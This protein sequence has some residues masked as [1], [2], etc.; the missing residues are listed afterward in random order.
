MQLQAQD[1]QPIPYLIQ[2]ITVGNTDIRKQ[3]AALQHNTPEAHHQA[4]KNNLHPNDYQPI[5]KE[6]SLS[7]RVGK[8]SYAHKDA[9]NSALP[10]YLIR[11]AL[12]ASIALAAL[13][14]V[15]VPVRLGLSSLATASREAGKFT[16]FEGLDKAIH[17]VSSDKN[18]QA[19]AG[20]GLSFSTF[21]TLF[22]TGKRNY[23]RIFGDKSAHDNA[24]AFH[25]LPR[26][27][28]NDLK[29]IA[30]VEFPA[31]CIAAIPLVTARNAFGGAA[32]PST[33]RDIIGCVPA[34]TVFFEAT[35]RLYS[36]FAN[37]QSALHG[38]Y[39]E[40]QPT[41]KSAD[42][43]DRKPY[44]EFTE[45]TPVRLAFRKLPA[46]ALGIAPYIALNRRAYLNQAKELVGE[47][48]A[49]VP[50]GGMQTADNEALGLKRDTFRSAYN[51]EIKPFL[52]FPAYTVISEAWMSNYDKLFA[53][54]QNKY[55]QRQ[56]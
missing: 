3:N 46:V 52:M 56:K 37:D 32:Q 5:I 2:P 7:D 27:I 26:N 31:T 53:K 17:A 20:V 30:P 33:M 8:W 12:N 24:V 44:A 21:R 18:V 1:N 19:I 35:E 15:I 54:L 28:F 40:A 10:N 36:G 47:E 45:D 16:G 9:M 29:E 22:K 51:K 34:Y 6:G 42:P 38:I 49:T 13:T 43:K 14:A 25:D 4:E 23:D 50:L 48:K 41:P 39:K 11:N 55:E